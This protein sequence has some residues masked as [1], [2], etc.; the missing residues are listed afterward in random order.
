M[1]FSS[2]ET[3]N[4]PGTAALPERDSQL[5]G[6]GERLCAR[7]G[8]PRVLG[9]SQVP[10]LPPESRELEGKQPA[11]PLPSPLSPH[12]AAQRPHL[13]PATERGV[14][15]IKGS[16]PAPPGPRGSPAGV[17]ALRH[18][19]HPKNWSKWWGEHRGCVPMPLVGW[20]KIAGGRR[21]SAG[22]WSSRARL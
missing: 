18:A 9:A 3:A 7:L 8:T 20:L 19:E 13:C 11:A 22:D 15:W 17:G 6:R 2:P 21:S 10:K 16:S 4:A 14:G 12:R 1:S 5:A